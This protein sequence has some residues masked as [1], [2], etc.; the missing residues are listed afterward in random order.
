[1]KFVFLL[2]S[3]AKQPEVQQ[4]WK[5]IAQAGDL[6]LREIPDPDQIFAFA[7]QMI[8][9]DAYFVRWAVISLC[10]SRRIRA[11]AKTNWIGSMDKS[12]KL[13]WH[14][15]VDSSESILQVFR[16]FAEL[17]MIPPVPEA[18]TRFL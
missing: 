11:M 16:E 10:I 12:R 6:K 2:S 13:G 3:W 1:V 8:L 18:R 15:F 14:G 9:G 17:K 5:E 7:D 4:A